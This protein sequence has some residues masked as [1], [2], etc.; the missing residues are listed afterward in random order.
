MRWMKKKGKLAGE[1]FIVGH[2]GFDTVCRQEAGVLNHGR[3][4]RE[5]F[6]ASEG[7]NIV[8]QGQI[9][10]RPAGLRFSGPSRTGT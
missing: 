7:A 4:V 8:A 9:G 10:M 5:W 1:G 3:D 2:A 6:A